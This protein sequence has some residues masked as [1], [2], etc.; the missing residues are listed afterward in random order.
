MRFDVWADLVSQKMSLCVGNVLSVGKILPVGIIL[1]VGT[2]MIRREIFTSENS[3]SGNMRLDMILIIM[4]I[5]GKIVA[6]VIINEE[7]EDVDERLEGS[8]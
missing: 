4:I 1:S 8:R 6:M 3:L 2:C 5:N 7:D